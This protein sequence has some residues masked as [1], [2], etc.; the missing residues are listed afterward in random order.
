MKLR[1]RT[2]IM[3]VGQWTVTQKRDAG[4]VCETN[5][6][7]GEN[8]TTKH[9]RCQEAWRCVSWSKWRCNTQRWGEDSENAKVIVRVGQ[10]GT[11]YKA[12]LSST[13]GLSVTILVHVAK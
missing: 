9:R 1:T 13:R 7:K 4:T 3:R 11:I 2:E 5:N 12:A 6:S 8:F 10:S